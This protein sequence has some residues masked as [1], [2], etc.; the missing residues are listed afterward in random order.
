MAFREGHALVSL[1]G[2]GS[3]ASQTMHGAS[4]LHKVHRH[5]AITYSHPML[6]AALRHPDT[7][8][9]MPLMP[10]PSVPQDGT[11]NNDGARH[12]ATRFLA[13]WRQDPPH[14][15][16]LVTA[17]SLRANAPPIHTL[18]DHGL[19]SMLGV[20]EGEQALLCQQVQ[21]SEHAGRVIS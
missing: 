18:Q 7:R 17:E 20:K 4:C 9:G 8:A 21:A 3:C 1:D 15:Q 14:V 19:H 16:C 6:G 10:E 13:T 5:G 12:A 11:D 2:T